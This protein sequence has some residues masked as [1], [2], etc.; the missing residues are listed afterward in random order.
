MTRSSR[1]KT[2]LLAGGALLGVTGLCQAQTHTSRQTE[3]HLAAHRDIAKAH[4]KGELLDGYN[5]ALTRG[6]PVDLS[7]A[8]RIRVDAEAVAQC[9][10]VLEKTFPHFHQWSLQL[11][12]EYYRLHS[13]NRALHAEYARLKNLPKWAVRY[14]LESSYDRR[15]AEHVI[16]YRIY[17]AKHRARDAMLLGMM[18]CI[19]VIQRHDPA[20]GAQWSGQMRALLAGR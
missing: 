16:A 10:A 6:S 18:F 7:E 20:L 17:L 11:R 3:Q 8:D 19:R 1:I 4:L 5:K 14:E 9:N 2:V 12:R 15:L 13:E